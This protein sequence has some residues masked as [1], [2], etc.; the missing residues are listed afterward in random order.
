MQ[1]M[2]RSPKMCDL[3]YKAE[4]DRMTSETTI[5]H[6]KALL[7]CESRLSDPLDDIQMIFQKI[8][9]WKETMKDK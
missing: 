9:K 2:L 7:L 5:A 4:K 1:A 6:L 3:Y 8:S